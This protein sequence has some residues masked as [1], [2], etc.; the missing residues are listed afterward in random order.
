[1]RFGIRPRRG[2]FRTLP[3][4]G[5]DLNELIHRCDASVLGGG[6]GGGGGSGPL[7]CPTPLLHDGQEKNQ[8]LDFIGF[9]PKRCCHG[10]KKVY[11]GECR[12][13][14]RTNKTVILK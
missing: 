12:S 5:D 13:N 2:F 7:H 11:K 8:L 4:R 1:M 10:N 14:I 3:W 6:G 9:C